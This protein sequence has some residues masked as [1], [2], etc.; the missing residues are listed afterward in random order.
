[1]Q[2]SR[3]D[4]DPQAEPEFQL[5]DGRLSGAVALFLGALCLLAVLCFRF[6]ELL[7]TPALRAVYP[8][9]ALRVV[10]FV[11][12]LLALGLG[13]LAVLL[14]NR[15][16]GIGSL[17]L[18]A[19]AIAL[20]GAWA[21]GRAVGASPHLGLDWFVLDL[22]GLALVFIPL[23]RAFAL[24]RDQRILRAGWP[25]DLAHFLVNHLLVSA[26]ALLTLAPA[27][28][29]L[30]GLVSP[31][32]QAAIAEQPLALQIVLAVAT[33]DL[34]QY[35]TH[36]AF[37][38]SPFLWRFHAIHHS[39]RALDWLA[40]SRLHLVDVIA[41]RALSFLPLF[42]L[43]ISEPALVAYLGIVSIQAVLLH[44][45]VRLRLGPLR[46]LVASPEFH[47]W[48]HAEAP[49]DKNFAVH[50]PLIDRLFGTAWLPGGFPE[51]YGIA[52]DPV[53]DGWW[54]QLRWPL[55]RLGP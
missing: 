49:V 12:L 4:V 27:R 10:L 13:A 23:E 32:L 25:T 6:P 55:R 29:L 39:S 1:M 2:P 44:A 8:L 38:A 45:N 42:F 5:G 41:T 22:L 14:G 15:R 37:H 50:L 33:A 54:R 17:A 19:A 16:A 43:G 28:L 36:R 47:H 30:G 20:G 52:G 34:F 9:F 46:W 40:G 31:R 24:V 26:L 18:T 51:R 21:P 11:A 53:P 48:H 3:A 35:G 7:T